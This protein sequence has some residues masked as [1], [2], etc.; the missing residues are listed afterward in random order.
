MNGGVS[1]DSWKSLLS[2][3]IDITSALSTVVDLGTR[4]E[5]FSVHFGSCSITIVDLLNLTNTYMPNDISCIVR[6]GVIV[7]DVLNDSKTNTS[8]Q[9]TIVVPTDKPQFST[10]TGERNALS[11]AKGY[12]EIMAFSR[13]G[14]IEQLEYEGYTTS[15]AIYAVDHC[16]ANWKDQAVKSAK[17]YLEIMSFSRSGLIEQLEYE[18]FTHE[19]A[20]Y[21]VTMN[22]Y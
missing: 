14:L 9:T 17:A 12:L 13:G 18:G 22:G 8:S 10:T 15:E 7:Y 21:G 20:I 6:D 16:G 4:D 19:Q 1:T 3:F 5:L 11:S 2:Q